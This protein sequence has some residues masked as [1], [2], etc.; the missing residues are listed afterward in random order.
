M[1]TKP[2]KALTFRQAKEIINQLSDEK[3]DKPMI[4]WGDERGFQIQG[5]MIAEEDYCDSGDGAEPRSVIENNLGDDETMDDYAVIIEK[6]D[7][8]LEID[9]YEE[10]TG[11]DILD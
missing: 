2:K 11:E 5:V 3:L 10:V 6:G 9:L 4:V 8:I 7:A 1:K